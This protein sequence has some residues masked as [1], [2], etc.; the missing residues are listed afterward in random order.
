MKGSLFLTSDEF[1]E[2]FGSI[3]TGTLEF[4]ESLIKAA[5]LQD[6][7]VAFSNARGGQIVLGVAEG[8]PFAIV[9][10]PWDQKTEERIQEV[11]RI[12]HP[13]VSLAPEPVQVDGLTVVVVEVSAASSGWVQT[14]DGRLLVRAG[15]TNRVLVGNELARFV[16]ERSGMAV[17]DASVDGG[18]I[19]D[20][21][22]ASFRSFL[23]RRVGRERINVASSARELGFLNPEGQVRLATLLL[24]GTSPQTASRRFGIDVV[25]YDGPLGER[26]AIRNRQR[27]TGTLEQLVRKAD[28]AIYDEMRHD[29]VIRGLIREE[30][31]EFPTVAL[32]EALVNAVGHRDYALTGA[33]VEVRIY[34][35]GL[36]IESPGSLAGW[37]TVENLRDAQY[38]RNQRIMD[39]LSTLG[40]VEEAGTGID[41][42]YEALDDALL[43]PP[44]FEERASSFVVRFSGHTVFS[45]EDRLWVS[46]FADRVPT[47]HGRVAL[48]YAR[49]H[50]AI[51]NEDL[52]GLRSLDANESRA[53]LVDLV[54][55]GLLVQLGTRRGT[56]YVLGDL[57]IGNEP[58]HDLAERLSSIVTHAHRTGA[59]T[60]TD[61]RG[62]LGVDRQEALDLLAFA[63]TR[64]LLEPVGERRAR[65][66]LPVVHAPPT[67]STR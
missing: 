44:Q 34:D 1:W 66:Y 24:F 40:L 17:E 41:R 30:V 23:R 28:R 58:A 67:G 14:S 37:V 36:E 38:S 53:V 8:P 62:L 55:R 29:A 6:P 48:V 11:A 35:D 32:R 10:V 45:A 7:V 27:L 25:R 3:E 63:V 33:S 9:G 47:G 56:R 20:L 19:G 46:R 59:I 18:T 39:A 61:V 15:P 5:R 49:R 2:R 64:G 42:M 51:R 16:S 50:G 22:G 52:R 60:N 65:K 12:T 54:Q 43:V 21:D 31:P 13:P 26:T 57:A 4:K